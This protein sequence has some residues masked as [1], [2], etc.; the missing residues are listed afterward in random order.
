[1]IGS[2]VSVCPAVRYGPL[3][4]KPF[5]REKFLTLL[6][7]KGSYLTKIRI[8]PN[9]G[10]DFQW[11]R[12]VL[13]DPNQANGICTGQYVLEIFSDASLTGWSA[14][15]G[16]HRTHGWWSEDDKTLHINGLELNLRLHSSL[17]NVSQL[18][19]R[20]AK[21]YSEST[22]S[23]PSHISIDSAQSSTPSSPLS[24]E[25]SG[26]GAREE[27]FSFLRLTLP[28]L[29]IR[30]PIGNPNAQTLTQNGHSRTFSV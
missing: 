10:E 28:R 8:S 18:I 19:F 29:K 16:P 25:T 27:I 11:W 17:L 21:Y 15:C 23:Q 2:L 9:L 4:T 24:P 3:Y 26:N 20:T 30:L 14:S 22:T 6:K 7:A 13:F 1:M 12:R 5:E